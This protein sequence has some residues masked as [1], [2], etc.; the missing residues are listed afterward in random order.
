MPSHDWYPLALHH[1]ASFG[2]IVLVGVFIAAF[3]WSVRSYLTLWH[4]SGPVWASLTN[5]PRVIW[6][7]QGDAHDTHLALHRKYGSLVRFGPNMVSVSDPAEILNIYGSNG[8]FEKSDFYW[9]LSFYVKGK[10]IPGLFATQDENIHRLLRR[11]IAGSYSMSNLVSFEPY[12]DSTMRVFFEQLNTRFG[13]TNQV[14]N[15]GTWLHMFAFDVIGAITFSKRLGF[16]ESGEDVDGIMENSWKYFYRAAP[17]TQMPWID[18]V[19]TKNPILQR[20]RI[21]KM[22]PIVAFAR[23]RRQEKE[24]YAKTNPSS[25]QDDK[26]HK[27]RDFLTRFM[28][29]ASKDPVT[30][31]WAIN[32]WATSN[33]TA[34]SDTTAILLRT[35]FY[36]LLKYPESMRSLREELN[37]RPDLSELVTW[38]EA[39]TLPYLDACIKEAGRMHPPFA[40]PYER[41][42]PPEG[43]TICSKRLPGGTVVGI[44]AWVLHRDRKTFGDDSDVWRPERWLECDAERRRKMENTLMTFGAGHRSCIGKN[45]SYLEIYKLVPTL[46]RTFDVS[47]ATF[48]YNIF[49]IS[50]LLFFA[51]DIEKTWEHSANIFTP[52][53]SFNLQTPMAASGA[54]R[55]VGSPIKVD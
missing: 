46:V 50:H 5:I 39:I 34:G 37:A 55:T 48:I 53:D 38:K 45:I 35:V 42:V 47:W 15:F 43:A 10:A 51:F 22:N 3:L 20:L 7:L 2:T 49:T 21:T 33:V 32:A 18:Y 19:Y 44:S 27:T 11:P 36:N 9:V 52:N 14:C 13:Q 30:P 29:V 24:E 28:E 40:L 6:V 16:L 31:P 23:A 41:V 4:V 12:V 25:A 26:E 8:K 54:W 1:G 17:V